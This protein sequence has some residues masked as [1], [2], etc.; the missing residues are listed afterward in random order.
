MKVCEMNDTELIQHIVD[1]ISRLK[2]QYG[3]TWDKF[4]EETG[5][6]RSTML[7]WERGKLPGIDKLYRICNTYNVSLDWLIG[8]SE[9]QRIADAPFSYGDWVNTIE[10]WLSTGVIKQFYIPELDNGYYDKMSSEL[11][12]LPSAFDM[13]LQSLEKLYPNMFPSLKMRKNSMTDSDA[14]ETTY[15]EHPR[16]GF[17]HT[18]NPEDIYDIEKDFDGTY[19]DIFQIKDTFL[20]CI[21]AKLSY[22][23][24][25]NSLED[26]NT[27]KENILKEFGNEQVLQL[28]VYTLMDTSYKAVFR[29][30]NGI[31]ELNL[32]EIWKYL[33]KLKKKNPE[34][35]DCNEL[36]EQYE[37][38]QKINSLL[39]SIRDEAE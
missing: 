2:K 10:N 1:N 14:E 35:W 25:Q 6:P 39:A 4:A 17:A 36:T 27:K 28:D 13:T 18:P 23:K 26:Y 19:P 8:N 33:K 29:K 24:S 11:E 31:A 21:L 9:Y 16:T 32:T 30:Y 20:R 12:K 34:H 15:K 3:K 5:I 38:M 22:Y 37:K 7:S